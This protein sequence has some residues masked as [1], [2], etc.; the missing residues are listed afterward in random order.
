MN[1][2]HCSETSVQFYQ[3]TW[4]HITKKRDEISLQCPHYKSF[5]S[6]SHIDNHLI[7]GVPSGFMQ[8]GTHMKILTIY[9]VPPIQATCSVW[10]F[11]YKM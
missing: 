7:L 9:Y 3:T 10:L 5:V 11:F 1:T 2:A 8:T 4:H 6:N